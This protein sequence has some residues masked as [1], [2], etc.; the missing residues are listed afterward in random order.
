MAILPPPYCWKAVELGIVDPEAVIPREWIYDF[1]ILCPAT[2]E[3][4][5]AFF[6]NYGASTEVDDNTYLA[7]VAGGFFRNVLN[8]TDVTRLLNKRFGAHA[9]VD[10]GF[11]HCLE[12]LTNPDIEAKHAKDICTEVLSPYQELATKLLSN[13]PAPNE[14]SIWS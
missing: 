10:S 4:C 7:L 2:P 6:R 1:C 11:R 8:A 14:F 13:L 9:L 3:D 12:M 5:V